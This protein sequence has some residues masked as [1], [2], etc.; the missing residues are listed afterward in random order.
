QMLEQR[1]AVQRLG[2]VSRQ[3]TQ[4]EQVVTVFRMDPG[5]RP[6]SGAGIGSVPSSP[7]GRDV[8]N[9]TFVPT[10]PTGQLPVVGAPAVPAPVATAP[11]L[12]GRTSQ[13]SPVAVRSFQASRAPAS[14]SVPPPAAPVRPS[15]PASHGGGR[16]GPSSHGHASAP[17]R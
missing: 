8:L 3:R 1:A 5:N 11:A 17:H 6:A 16:S 9:R 12:V 7:G 2:E 15:L 4:T 10:G 14:R 13:P